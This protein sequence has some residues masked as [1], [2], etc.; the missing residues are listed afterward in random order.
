MQ[1][2]FTKEEIS[3]IQ[4]A[5]KWS[6]SHENRYY[7]IDFNNDVKEHLLSSLVE[8]FSNYHIFTQFTKQEFTF[9]AL[10]LHEQ[11]CILQEENLGTEPLYSAFE[12]CSDCAEA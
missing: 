6:S 11:I 9:L 7:P 3:Y 4:V 12:K 5:L 10:A 2:S 8:K 1:T